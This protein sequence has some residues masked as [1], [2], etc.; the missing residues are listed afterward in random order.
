MYYTLCKGDDQTECTLWYK[1][2]EYEGGWGVAKKLPDFINLKGFTAM[3]PTV[4]WDLSLKKFVLYFVSDRPGGQGQLDVWCSPI[5]WD[6]QFETPF[7]LGLNSPGDDVTP[8]FHQ[9]SQTLYFSTNGRKGIGRF[10]IFRAEKSE[11]GAWSQPVNP[12]RPFNSAY[13]DLYFTLHESSQIAYLTSDR[14]GSLC[15]GAI[16]GQ[17]CYDLYEVALPQAEL[18]QFANK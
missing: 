11:T 8:Y 2:R 7:S 13:D 18:A 9:P 10:D 12:G 17:A 3:Q 15:K 16:E 5:T 4:G 1:D 14:P 6:G